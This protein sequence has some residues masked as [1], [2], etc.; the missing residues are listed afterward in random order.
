MALAPG[1]EPSAPGPT[2]PAHLPPVLEQQRRDLQMPFTRCH[3]QWVAVTFD[4][5]VDVSAAVEQQADEIDV[6]SASR[7]DQRTAITANRRV[8][9]RPVV[10]EAT[11]AGDVAVVRS[12]DE[13]AVE[14]GV[15]GGTR[16][17][18][19]WCA[20]CGRRN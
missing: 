17:R 10:Q 16:T 14:V 13:G 12:F 11:H 18:C 2:V 15:G 4:D 1:R 6:S 20:G 7:R 9:V 8:D 19:A 3:D 5:E